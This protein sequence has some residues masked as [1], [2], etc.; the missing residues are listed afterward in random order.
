MCGQG[1]IIDYPENIAQADIQDDQEYILQEF[2][3]TSGGIPGVIAGHHDLRV[4]IASGE[5]V[6]SHVRT[7]KEGSLLAN[8]AQGGSI[9]EVAVKDI[10]ESIITVVKKIQA[11]IDKR[12]DYPLYSID[13]GIQHKETAFV[14]ELNDQ[15]GFPSE[16]MSA[17]KE[18]LDKILDSLEHRASI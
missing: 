7:P 10:P 8:V 4:V 17:K 16:D 9:K 13:L 1:I 6:L 11:L 2:V 5:I 14:F 3:D 12:F 15:I 18:F